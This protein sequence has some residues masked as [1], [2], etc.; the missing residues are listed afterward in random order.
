MDIANVTAQIKSPQFADKAQKAAQQF[1][2]L[3]VN[4]MMSHVYNG[5]EVNEYFGGG[6]GEEIFRSL[7]VEEYSKKI[8][9]SKQ[10]KIGDMVAREMLKMQE[11]QQ[12][13]NKPL[14]TGA[15][16]AAA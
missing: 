4:E 5:I 8:A 7:M 13:P 15:I 14:T 9:E 12:N 1:E 16:H 10:T 11:L 3:F 6:R 2:A